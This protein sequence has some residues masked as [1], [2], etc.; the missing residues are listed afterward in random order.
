VKTTLMEKTRYFLEPAKRNFRL[1]AGSPAI[2]KSEDGGTIGALEYP[3]VYYVDPSHPAATDEPAWGY[4][5]VPLATL[6][7]A[8]AIAQAG[9]T[10]ILRG[11]V[12]RETLAPRNTGVTIRAMKGEQVI[13]SGADLIE[14]WRHEPN[15][16]W[17]ASLMAEPKKLLRDGKPCLEFS[18]D[19]TG[20]RVLVKEREPRVHRWES[21]VREYGID[22]SKSLQVKIEGIVVT[23]TLQGD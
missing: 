7:R 13:I 21:V 19:Q 23:D 6:A 16:D 15:G 3:N 5:A 12:Y 22:V 2:G 4:A 8:C 17:S 18:Y 9:E 20:K 1:Q 11:G 14:D 10:I